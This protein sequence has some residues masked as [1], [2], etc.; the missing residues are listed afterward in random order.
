MK[1]AINVAAIKDKKILLVNKNGTWILPG[2]KLEPGESDIECLE[3]EVQEELSGILINP[4][5]YGKFSGIT[6]HKKYPLEAKV[7]FGK[8]EGDL[9]PRNEISD[10]EYVSDLENYNASNITQKILDS[11]K[12]DGYL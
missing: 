1:V 3:R 12:K 5:Y 2:G 8:I 11:L 9:T 10:L 4:V 7:Y 6:P